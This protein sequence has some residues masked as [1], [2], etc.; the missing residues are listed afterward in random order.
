MPK[1]RLIELHASGLGVID[2]A[3][4]EFGQ[5]FNVITGE[6]GAGKTLLLD[7]LDLCLG[8]DGASSR[9]AFSATMRVAAVFDNRDGREVV[10]TREAGTN[11]R[12]RSTLEG[13]PSSAEALRRVAHDLIVIHGQ[14]DS[15][16]LRHRSEVLA[17]LDASAKIDAG[18]LDQARAQ[19]REV[20]RLRDGL[21]GDV[22][23]RQREVEL[24][25]FQI[26]ELEESKIRL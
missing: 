26:D 23:H 25:E 24:A 17:I 7:A 1:S 3:Q 4:V 20:I 15:L 19:L 12:L 21:G 2:S 5:G 8:G 22:L 13:A 6:T 11:G 16:S 18:P 10:L 14:H 9:H